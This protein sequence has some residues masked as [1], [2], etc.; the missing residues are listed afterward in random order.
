MRRFGL[1]SAYYAVRLGLRFFLIYAAY[2]NSGEIKNVVF[3]LFYVFSSIILNRPHQNTLKTFKNI[4]IFSTIWVFYLV[5]K[6]E[7]VR[8][9]TK[10]DA[11][12]MLLAFIDKRLASFLAAP[13]DM[14]ADR[15]ALLLL[16]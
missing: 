12:H 9:C 13:V 4:F 10:G 5:K 15:F 7:L 6:A 14:L 11:T 3:K 16:L 8:I 2:P 1:F